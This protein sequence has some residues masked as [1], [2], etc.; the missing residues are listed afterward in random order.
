[1]SRAQTEVDIQ[2]LKS[3]LVRLKEEEKALQ[4][5]INIVKSQISAVQVC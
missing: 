5:I 3:E 4:D 2:R 1:M